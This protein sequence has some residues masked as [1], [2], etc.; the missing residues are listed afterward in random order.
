MHK[1]SWNLYEQNRINQRVKTKKEN[2]FFVIHWGKSIVTSTS[3]P[4]H[5]SMYWFFLK[6]WLFKPKKFWYQ[7]QERQNTIRNS[8]RKTKKVKKKSK[9]EFI[10]VRKCHVSKRPTNPTKANK[11]KFSFV[12]RG[13]KLLIWHQVISLQLCSSTQSVAWLNEKYNKIISS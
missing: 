11:N 7:N 9:R 1:V 12:K 3:F 10:M 4:W 2:K 8:R 6:W 5:K 13:M